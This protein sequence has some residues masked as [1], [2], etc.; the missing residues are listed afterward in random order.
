MRGSTPCNEGSPCSEQKANRPRAVPGT[1]LVLKRIL[2]V[3]W[4]Q[5]LGGV[6]GSAITRGGVEGSREQLEE[7]RIVGAVLGV[8]LFVNAM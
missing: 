8:P 4:G 6:E 5:A 2:I 7:L 3:H 1:K